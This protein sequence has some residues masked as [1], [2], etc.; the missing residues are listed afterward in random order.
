MKKIKDLI[1]SVR[2]AAQADRIIV[3]GKVRRK[4]HTWPICLTCGREPYAVNIVDMGSQRVDVMAKCGHK[5][6]WLMTPDDKSFEDVIT[7]S[8]P[9]GANST[10]RQEYISMA[11]KNGRFF[12]PAAPS[13]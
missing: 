7:V 10:E 9:F 6:Y 12:D 5:P 1:A 13:K 4:N 11:I 8:I 2:E 3:P